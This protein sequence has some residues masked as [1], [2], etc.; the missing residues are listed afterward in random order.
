MF[1][2]GTSS[3]GQFPD[4]STIFCSELW[5]GNR[6]QPRLVS[7]Q[8]TME[9]GSQNQVPKPPL[10]SLRPV[11]IPLDIYLVILEHSSRNTL[12][13]F[14]LVSRLSYHYAAPLL[15]KNV[16]LPPEE[17]RATQWSNALRDII[18]TQGKHVE[19]IE[20]SLAWE[21]RSEELSWARPIEAVTNTLGIYLL[22]AT[23]H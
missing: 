18:K 23:I 1:D 19:T 13:N 20:F 14:C 6:I 3:S 15:W 17:M 8:D 9:A 22:S 16:N 11:D 21:E 10:T 5:P 4:M 7:R 12:R 2:P